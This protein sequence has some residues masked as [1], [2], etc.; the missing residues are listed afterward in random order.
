MTHLRLALRQLVKSPGFTVVAVLLLALGIGANTAFFSV[1]K[2]QVLAPF[3][4]PDAGRVVQLWRTHGLAREANPWSI[5]DFFDVQAQASSFA[6]MGA[7][8]P[9]NF[10]LGGKAPAPV[11]GIVCTAGALRALGVRPALGRWFTDRDEEMGVPAVVILSHA[12]WLQQF[13]G[14]PAVIGRELRID[15]QIY[16]A[17]GVMPA[18]FEFYCPWTDNTPIALWV[19]L[20]VPRETQSRG[21]HW[22]LAVGRLQPGVSLAAAT[23]ELKVIAQR[24][25]AAHPDTNFRKSFYPVPLAAELARQAMFRYALIEAA[26][27]L[28]LAVASANL[29]IMFLARGS[30]RQVEYAVRL[31]LGAS[32]GDLVRL[33]LAASLAVTLLGGAAGVW[34]AW[35]ATGVLASIFVPFAAHGGAVGIDRGVLGFSLALALGSALAAGLPPALTAARTDVMATIKE[36]SLAQAGSRT[37]HRF[38]RQLVGAQVTVALLLANTALLLLANHRAALAFSASLSSEYAL[39][40]KITLKGVPYRD[41]QACLAFWERFLDRVRALP[42][43]TAA[44]VTTQ[45]PL[46]GENTTTLLANDETFD[47]RI[48]RPPIDVAAVSPDYFAALGLGRRAGRA[49]APADAHAAAPG[50]VVNRQLAATYWPGEDGLGR[51]LRNDGPKTSFTATVVGVVDDVRQRDIGAPAQPEM[52]LPFALNPTDSAYLVVRSAFVAP[53]LA[54]GLRRELAALDPDLALAEPTTMAELVNDAA[55]ARRTLLQL[56]NFFMAATLLMAAI[57]IYGTLSFQTRQR[58]REIGVRLA[59]GATARDIVALVVGQTVPWLVTGAIAGVLLS[60]GVALALR[61]FFAD[62]NLMNPIYYTGGLVA[63]GLV[64]AFACWFPARRATRV[65]PVEALRAE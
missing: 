40:A 46:R 33:A 17:V 61:P 55:R 3:P 58:T 43:V 16:T 6:A 19:P 59:L 30:G 51:T 56:T 42:G 21:N 4:Y 65:N 45:L 37:R 28:V 31:A 5:P 63:L 49:L 54:P 60:I 50:V 64:L 13:G 22:L 10:T 12:C 14:D 36:G 38:L 41:R 25:E 48:R 34:L 2:A 62:V 24:L 9:E 27:A 47:P 23:A 53:R 39:T 35:N 26:V 44:A 52:F 29:A 20:R 15:G 7:F 1:I 18:D 8:R 32:R 57:G 11:T